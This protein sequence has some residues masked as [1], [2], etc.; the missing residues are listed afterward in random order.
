[1]PRPAA[2]QRGHGGT[3]YQDIATQKPGA[4]AH[5]DAALYDRNF[6]DMSWCPARAWQACTR[7]GSPQVNSVHHQGIKDL[8]PGFVVEARSPR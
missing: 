6:H 1:V 4:L 3:L 2:D 7:A 5:R 8:A